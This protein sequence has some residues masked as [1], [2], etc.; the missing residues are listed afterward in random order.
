MRR[1]GP[2]FVLLPN[3][4]AFPR[5][6][7]EDPMTNLTT[8][9]AAAAAIGALA[10]PASAQ[11][12]QPYPYPYPQQ[13]PQGYPGYPGYPQGY[14]QNPI[15]QIIGQLLG[16]R[17][18]LTDRQ[19]VSRCASAAM[20]QAQNQ[21]RG[22]YNQG[23]PYPQGYPGYQ[24]GFAAPMKRVTAITS[25]ERRSNGL[26]VR[27][28]LNSGAAVQPYG[29]AYGYQNQGYAAVGDLAFRCN[30]DYRGVV[31]N[32]RISRNGAYRRY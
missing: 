32:V 19:A 31:T 30:V 7:K 6:T 3:S 26:R 17:Y 2:E 24:Q 5:E 23:Y 10:A 13:Y 25:V 20:V 27:G 8:H 22:A 1:I 15:D 16:N 9:L 4:P 28:L 21:Y 29:Q 11:Y 14:G 18:S 12:G